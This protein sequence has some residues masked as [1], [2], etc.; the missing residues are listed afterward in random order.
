VIAGKRDQVIA[1]IREEQGHSVTAEA[2][3]AFAAHLFS[4]SPNCYLSAAAATMAAGI[5]NN[6]SS[7]VCDQPPRLFALTVGADF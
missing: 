5:K 4:E 1:R 6:S 2:F 3:G 7:R